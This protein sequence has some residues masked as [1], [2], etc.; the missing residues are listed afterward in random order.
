M[1]AP[2]DSSVSPRERDRVSAE[3]LDR[4]WNRILRGES[5]IPLDE[6][7]MRVRARR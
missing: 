6:L 4:R 7:N 5:F 3:R 1:G 2:D